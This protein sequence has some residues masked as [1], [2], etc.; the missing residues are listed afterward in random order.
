MIDAVERMKSVG[1]RAQ[2]GGAPTSIFGSAAGLAQSIDSEEQFRISVYP[3]ICAQS[4]ETA[5]GLASCLAYLLEQY[6][7][8]RVYRCFAKFNSDDEN[9]EIAA[10]DYQF[11]VTDWELTGLADNVVLYGQLEIGAAGY[12]LSL[13]LDSGLLDEREAQ[14][15]V[16]QFETLEAAALA[17]PPVAAQLTAALAGPNYERALI[18]YESAEL[19]DRHLESLLESVFYWNLDVYLS[20]WDVEW[21]T[22]DRLE[23]F[24]EVAGLSKIRRSEFA[25]WCLGMMTEQIMQPGMAALGEALLPELAQS[26]VEDSRFAGGAAAAATGL[27]KLDFND[28]AIDL[29]GRYLTP[30]AGAGVW[31]RATEIHLS[32]AQIPSAID[33]CQRALESGPEHPALCW[34]Y[35]Q[36]LINAETHESEVEALLF[37]DPE[38]VAEE[39]QIPAEIMHA[40]K[41]HIELAPDNLRALQLALTYMIDLDDAEL[42]SYFERLARKDL[43]GDYAGV[44]IDRLLDAPEH[45]QAY[46]VLNG[47]TDANP[48]SHALLAQLALADEDHTLAS[49]TI[50]TCRE[51]LAEIDDSL[52]AELQRL[53][54]SAK[55]PGF[56][57]S[58]AEIK[59]QLGGNSQATE[60]QVDLLESAVD[61][62]PRMIDLYIALSRCYLSWQDRESALEVL[63]DAR[64]GAGDAPQIDLGLARMLWASGE[65]DKAIDQLNAGLEAFP[66]DVYLLAQMANYLIANDQLEDAR[67][68][69]VRAESIAPSHRAIWQVRHLVAQKMAQ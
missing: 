26:F 1:Q 29:V 25:A 9:N 11:H 2:D 46:D 17:L 59:L 27:A 23:Q 54:L 63:N 14:D 8:T 68:F 19:D 47:A 12:D 33:A 45:E 49:E 61:I 60:E 35:A 22:E 43:T 32:A 57:A 41:S 39:E 53:E 50:Q 15:F 13:V 56:E 30:E 55:L 38:A 42:W 37:A 64:Q 24:R 18:E 66:S 31:Y 69:I 36:L 28:S 65:R 16:F 52:E 40:L 21:G 6:I 4:P 58:F 34:Q 48:Y 20:F 67:P 5:M 3:I 44:I 62:A 51:R 7:D 10:D